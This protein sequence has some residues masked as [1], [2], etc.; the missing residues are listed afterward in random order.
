MKE[1]KE[2]QDTFFSVFEG[3]IDSINT[4]SFQKQDKTFKKVLFV[5]VIDTLAKCAYPHK[6]NAK[7]FTSFID[8]F[9]QWKHCNK[10]SLTNLIR[11]LSIIPDPAFS[12]LRK[13]TLS[14]FDN[15]HGSIEK[16]PDLIDIQKLWPKN[17]EYEQNHPLQKFNAESLTHKWLFY[18]YRNHLVHGLREPGY[19]IESEENTEPFYHTM[20]ALHEE[21][22]FS[23]ELV[24]PLSFFNCL[25]RCGFKNLK[26]YC[27]NN[28][29]DPYES[30]KETFGTY[31]ME[32]LN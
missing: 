15:W 17:I 14:I 23:W 32:E 20:G 3:Y 11:L 28:R 1:I 7:R 24:Y 16:D 26:T 4:A 27:E 9:C 5:S 30:Y 12:D 8:K 2:R 6:S 19:G 10:V 21:N 25:C 31:W 13:Y 18:K 22:S 29:I